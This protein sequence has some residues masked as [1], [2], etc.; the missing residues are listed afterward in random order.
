MTGH[1]ISR[2]RFS[3]LF[4][5]AVI[6]SLSV[7]SCKKK[8]PV[9]DEINS[10][11]AK[12]TEPSDEEL[13]NFYSP[14][15]D[16]ASWVE[17]LLMQIEEER[18]AEELSKMESTLEDYQVEDNQSGSETAVSDNTEPPEELNPIEK[19]FEEAKEGKVITG[20]NNEL[21]FYEFDKEIL[22]PQ[23]TADGLVVVHSNDSSVTRNFYDLKYQLIKKEEWT[24]KSASDAKKLKTEEFE[25]SEEN[26]KVIK[27]DIVTEKTRES[28]LYNAEGLPS[29]STKYAVADDKNYILMER[30]WT[31]NEQNKVIK[32]VQNEYLYKSNDYSDKP[33]LFSRRYEYT[34]NDTVNQNEEGDT[35]ENEIPPDSK[36]YEN[37]VLKMKKIYTAQK[38]AYYTWVYFDE[39]LAVKTYYEDDIRV[40]DE[41]YNNGKLFRIKTYEKP[42]TQ[43]EQT[44]GQTVVQG[45]QR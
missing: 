42:Q 39:N 3:L 24:I 4:F 37:N 26:G 35:E 10:D 32:D 12:T 34:F 22:A 41:F 11:T 6:L 40:R 8:N 13:Y 14:A 38:G 33:E 43:E 25:Y 19:F 23:F 27:K 45:E 21:R 36:Y 15:E 20:K 44:D 1:F 31:Y 17:S 30:I 2:I 7:I 28:V 16:D 5:V 18:I 29:A 9:V